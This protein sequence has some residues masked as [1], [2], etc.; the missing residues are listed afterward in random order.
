M[1]CGG[2]DGGEGLIGNQGEE[3]ENSTTH[4]VSA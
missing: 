2:E 1:N 3:L 4:G